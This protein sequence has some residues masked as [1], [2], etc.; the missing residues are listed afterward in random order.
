MDLHE[1]KHEAGRQPELDDDLT[2][3][4]DIPS[5]E[6]SDA[7]LRLRIAPP[8]SARLRRRLG[9]TRG[10]F[11]ERLTQRRQYRDTAATGDLLSQS[12]SRSRSRSIKR[13]RQLHLLER[14]PGTTVIDLLT[15][16]LREFLP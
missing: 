11:V 9:D 15:R 16:E 13:R 6:W 1:A 10:A 7:Q 2:W 14:A 5:E 8:R 3:V 12:R 4:T